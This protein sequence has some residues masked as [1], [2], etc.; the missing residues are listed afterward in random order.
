MCLAPISC[1]RLWFYISVTVALSWL[2]SFVKLLAKESLGSSA[3]HRAQ[4]TWSLVALTQPVFP[5][6]KSFPGCSGRTEND[7]MVS[8][9]SHRRAASRYVGTSQWFVYWPIHMWM[10][11]LMRQVQRRRL[12]LL[13]WRWNTPRQTAVISY[14]WS[15]CVGNW[16]YSTLQLARF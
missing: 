13:A 12:P 15:S 2:H 9:W 7:Q 10:E 11:P 16:A 3:G 6:L 4:T 8:L 14:V 1:R 5:S